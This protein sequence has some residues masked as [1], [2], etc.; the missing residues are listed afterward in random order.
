[1]RPNWDELFMMVAILVAT[2]AT[3]LKRKVGACIAVANHIVATGYNGAPSGMENCLDR[4]CCYYEKKACE[5]LDF[6]VT[7]EKKWHGGSWPIYQKFKENF[8]SYCVAV[9]AE[10][11]TVA[12][13]SKLGLKLDGG[14]LY[15]TN[16][17]CPR[18]AKVTVQAGIKEVISWQKYLENHFS[19]FDERKAALE[20]FQGAGVKVREI[21]LPDEKVAGIGEQ[22][23][24]VGKRSDYLFDGAKKYL[25]EFLAQD[26]KRRRKTEGG[27]K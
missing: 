25:D 11:N 7:H 21:V 4:S 10:E 6:E 18:C 9:H 14:K 27:K 3:C 26:K 8:K 24:D 2:R 20:I 13:G 16:F 22:M 17:P 19:V 15:I 12:Q 5:Q 23:S 1:M